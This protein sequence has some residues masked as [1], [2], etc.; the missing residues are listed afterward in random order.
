MADA[1]VHVLEAVQDVQDAVVSVVP[2]T[3]TPVEIDVVESLAPESFPQL[4]LK[5]PQDLAFD[6]TVTCPEVTK[7][8]TL[9]LDVRV[10]TVGGL[11]LGSAALEVVCLAPPRP[12]E[13]EEI[14][15]V[16][17]FVPLVGLPLPPQRPP[18]PL[19]EPNP[20][21]N[22]QSNPQSGFV[23]QEQ[24]QPQ[25]AMVHQESQ[26][27]GVAEETATDQ[28]LMTRHVERTRAPFPAALWLGSVV[29]M[30]LI[31][32]FAMS[33]REQFRT[34]RVGSGKPRRHR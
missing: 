28:Y 17:A 21:P 8:T 18:D 7:T 15:P 5:R 6:V 10:A 32:G 19:P 22:T 23:S 1:I 27:A 9:P 13:P 33:R 30:T 2:A 4:D 25:A 3:E 20:A 12:E 34:Q 16:T 29:T 24:K 31:Y 11:G 14:I 26:S